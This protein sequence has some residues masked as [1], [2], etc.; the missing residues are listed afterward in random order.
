MNVKT[1]E[2]KEGD[3]GDMFS[4]IAHRYDLLNRLLSFGLDKSWRRKAIKLLNVKTESKILDIATGTGDLAIESAR[5]SPSSSIIGID[6][7]EQMLQIGRKKLEQMKFSER[8]ILKCGAAENLSELEDERF[9]YVT[10][11]FGVRNFSDRKK[12][13][14][15]IY[16]VLKSGGSFLVLEFSMPTT[17]V[18][19]NIYRYYFTKILPALAG[20]ISSRS[21]YQY[22][23]DSV[24]E[25][26]SPKSFIELLKNIG[27][28]E[29]SAAPFTFGTVTCYIATK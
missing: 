29:V 7:S 4:Q 21:A 27:F 16:R 25:F 2:N 11:A 12:G 14:S 13:L 19:G 6:I 23:P 26:P 24:A 20:L 15:E 10:V 9:D 5:Q 22:L 8:V 18:L 28:L 3:I 17:P 1:R